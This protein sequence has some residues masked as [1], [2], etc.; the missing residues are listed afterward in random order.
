MDKETQIAYNKLY[1]EEFNGLVEKLKETFNT[2]RVR[3]SSIRFR[4]SE[5]NVLKMRAS[6]KKSYVQLKEEGLV[7]HPTYVSIFSPVIGKAKTFKA[8]YTDTSNMLSLNEGE[9]KAYDGFKILDVSYA[10]EPQMG[11]KS[12]RAACKKHEIKL[13]SHRIA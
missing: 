13:E 8:V 2:K 4:P 11:W 5:E 1:S 12:L 9:L 7:L 10:N 3:L 6:D